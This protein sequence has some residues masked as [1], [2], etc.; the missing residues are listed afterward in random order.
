MVNMGSWALVDLRKRNSAGGPY[1]DQLVIIRRI[2]KRGWHTE[3]YY[4]GTCFTEE[5]K[6]WFRT[7]S[8]SVFDVAKLKKK[9]D[10]WWTPLPEAKPVEDMLQASWAMR[11]E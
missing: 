1:D 11:N 5:G 2:E 7:S 6:T 8:G 10:L 4:I 9:Y 3:R